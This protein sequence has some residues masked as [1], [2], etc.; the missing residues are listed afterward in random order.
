M[1]GVNRRS[2]RGHTRISSKNQATIP[3]DALRRAGLKPGDELVV[4]AAGAG[5]ITLVLADDPIERHAGK[6]AGVYPPGYLAA[7]RA[8]WRD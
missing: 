8:E 5:R 1:T 6:G 3:V 4:Q 7:L 2:R